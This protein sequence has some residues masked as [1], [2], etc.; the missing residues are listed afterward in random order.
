MLFT[1]FLTLCHI[2]SYIIYIIIYYYL[3]IIPSCV[4][5]VTYDIIRILVYNKHDVL[6]VREVLKKVDDTSITMYNVHTIF[7]H[8]YLHS[9]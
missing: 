7:I 9:I 3:V 5:T 6:Y 8:S 2:Y 4:V 1:L